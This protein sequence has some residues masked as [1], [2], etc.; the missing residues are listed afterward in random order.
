V[1]L[2]IRN[3]G[4]T[5]AASVALTLAVAGL[6]AGTQELLNVMFLGFGVGLSWGAAS[7]AVNRSLLLDHFVYAD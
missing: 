1:P 6:P 3:F 2:S 4:N 7:M 5:S